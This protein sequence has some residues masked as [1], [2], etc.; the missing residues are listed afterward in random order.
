VMLMSAALIGLA[1]GAGFIIGTCWSEQTGIPHLD[2]V[3]SYL[4]VHLFNR[5]AALEVSQWFRALGVP[6]TLTTPTEYAALGSLASFLFM[7]SVKV[8]GRSR[9]S[10]LS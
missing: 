6:I 1:W 5:K 2:A 4:R 8:I 3:T 10:I 7:K 9:Q